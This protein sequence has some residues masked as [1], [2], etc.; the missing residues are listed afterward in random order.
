MKFIC[1]HHG[2][3]KIAEVFHKEPERHPSFNHNWDVTDLEVHF[4]DGTIMLCL[5]ED[6]FKTATPIPVGIAERLIK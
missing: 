6:F 3:N 2:A 1:N 5:K 4:D